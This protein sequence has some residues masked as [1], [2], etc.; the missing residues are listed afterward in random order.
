MVYCLQVEKIKVVSLPSRDK[1]R[2]SAR[3]RDKKCYTNP[4]NLIL[5]VSFN[6]ICYWGRECKSPLVVHHDSSGS[7]SPRF[8][9]E[10]CLDK[11]RKMEKSNQGCEVTTNTSR[12][13]LLFSLIVSAPFIHSFFSEWNSAKK[14]TGR[15]L[16]WKWTHDFSV[17]RQP[18]D[19]WT[20]ARVDRLSK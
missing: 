19:L 3:Y 2:V 16:S 17:V 20:R 9:H 10:Q 11:A 8:V 5:I 1:R 18:L 13:R 4:S 12:V 14:S 6:R 15:F 7:G